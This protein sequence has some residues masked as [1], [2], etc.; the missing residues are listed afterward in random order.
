MKIHDKKPTTIER[1]SK[2]GTAREKRADKQGAHRSSFSELLAK[3]GDG[4]KGQGI[5]DHANK[6][7]E[8]RA[9]GDAL[10]A[11][12]QE[13]ASLLDRQQLTEHGERKQHTLSFREQREVHKY[14]HRLETHDRVE[15]RYETRQLERREGSGEARAHDLQDSSTP[16]GRAS[17]DPSR[18]AAR[19]QRREDALAAGEGVDALGEMPSPERV[20]RA[21]G[22]VGQAGATPESA[23]REEVRALANKLVDACQ[24][25][26]D[27]QARKVM[28]LDLRVPGRG[29]IRVRLR[30][31][32][33][34]ISVRMR[35]DNDELKSLLRAHQ[36]SLR[37][38]ANERGAPFARIDIV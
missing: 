38:A 11:R 35:A 10:A 36:G 20:D 17:P 16:A 9:S 1:R 3:D 7:G 21:S 4:K 32:G 27:Q 8:Q 25:G 14:E 29:N 19:E 23:R 6:S 26:Q 12:S 30:Q 33:N 2:D 37:D 15:Q 34:G 24:V 13:D 31:E 5:L 28:M 18:P 22:E